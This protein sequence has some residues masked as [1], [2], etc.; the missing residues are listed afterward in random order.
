MPSFNY[1]GFTK[2]GKPVKGAKEAVSRQA[3]LMQLTAEGLLISEIHAVAPKRASVFSRLLSGRKNLSDVYF[4]L[5]L[6]LK[7]GIP[8][9]EAIHIIVG[10]TKSAK[11]REIFIDTAAK[12][13]EGMK[14]SDA[15]SRHDDY[16]DPMYVNLIKASEKMGRLAEVLL[17][18][19]EYEEQKRKNADKL[20]SA[21]VYPITILILGVGI[22]AFLLTAIVPKMQSVFTAAKQELPTSTKILLAVSA[23]AKVYGGYI[24]LLMIIG[25]IVLAYMYNNN[26]KFRM[27]VD[28]RFF[29]IGIVAQNAISRFSYILAF[30]L[31]EG[32]PLTDALYFATATMK[33]IYMKTLLDEVREKVQAG[34]KFSTAVRDAKV[35]PELFPAAVSTG[36]SSGNLPDLL[37]RVNEFYGRKIEKYTAS[38]L[39]VLEPLFIVIIGGLVGFV[40]ISIMQPLFTM[41]TMV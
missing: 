7:S 19:A 2:A 40:V 3:A 37:Q 17:D 31:R 27:K 8:L 29:S 23:F 5:S 21:I 32:L 18:I 38:L 16:F 11:E 10:T 39:S 30:Q 28:K 24:V 4:Q 20:T 14:F 36:E 33:N 9:V 12:V 41:N 25:G 26:P 22:L 15:L 6:L 1:S 13:S 35:F 34:V